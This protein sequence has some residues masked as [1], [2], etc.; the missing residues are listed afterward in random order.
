MRAVVNFIC[1]GAEGGLARLEM[2][3]KKKKELNEKVWGE[4]K[5][6]LFAMVRKFIP[7]WEPPT[8]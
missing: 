2:N 1:S 6:F 5:T 3:E 4:E 8:K 7:V